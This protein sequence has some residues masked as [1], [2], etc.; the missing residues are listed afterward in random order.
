M[1]MN[2]SGDLHRA[3]PTPAS[4]SEPPT[5]SYGNIYTPHAGSMIIHVQRESG[6]QSRTIVLGARSVRALRFVMSRPGKILVGSLVVVVLLISVEAARVPALTHRMA[7]MEHTAARLDSLERSLGQLQ[8]RYD[9]VRAMMGADSSVAAGAAH[10]VSRAITPL[11]AT[12]PRLGNPVA[13]DAD[14]VVSTAAAPSAV[15]PS[16]PLAPGD[17]PAPVRRRRH[18]VIAAPPPPDSQPTPPDSG[19]T[20]SAQAEPQ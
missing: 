17:S 12:P 4:S 3:S 19:S 9:Q 2:D 11:P 7:R 10:A 15:A 13:P 5:L 14:S 18:R 8:K 20:P 6:L 16:E 1:T